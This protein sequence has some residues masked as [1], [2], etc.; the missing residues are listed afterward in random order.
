VSD[1]QHK[2]VFVGWIRE[3]RG[4]WRAV[5]SG[6]SYGE[7]WAELLM[8]KCDKHADRI[9]LPVQRNPNRERTRR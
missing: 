3:A 7:A 9:V 8:V 2:P 1:Q 6:A 5:S 4:R